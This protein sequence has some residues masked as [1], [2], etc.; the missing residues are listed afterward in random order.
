MQESWVI[1][2]G[3]LKFGLTHDV[4]I[5]EFP[6]HLTLERAM[7]RYFG[8]TDLDVLIYGDTHVEAIDVFGKTLCV[9][10]GS[11]TYPRNLDTQMGTIGFID[12]STNTTPSRIERALIKVAW[13]L[14][15]ALPIIYVCYVLSHNG[16]FERDSATLF[17]ALGI[18][19]SCL[20]GA[21]VYLGF[22]LVVMFATFFKVRPVHDAD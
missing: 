4:P 11:P 12:I 20:A 13:C 21:G 14:F 9:N 19:M 7:M 16:Y 15:F 6:P 17:F 22:V 10:P 8:T 3:G 2:L 5:P 1:E 18:L